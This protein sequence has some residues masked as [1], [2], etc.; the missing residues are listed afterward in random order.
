MQQGETMTSPSEGVLWSYIS[1]VGWQPRADLPDP[2][3]DR[4]TEALEGYGYRLATQLV[5]PSPGSQSESRVE[6]WL[7]CDIPEQVAIALSI[8]GELRSI[9]FV[10]DLPSLIFVMHWA[11]VV[12]R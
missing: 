7:A 4:W 5:H 11:D 1:G 2:P 6:L 10:G 3:A 9:V 8:S 12:P